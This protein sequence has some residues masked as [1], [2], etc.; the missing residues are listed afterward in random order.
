MSAARLRITEIFHS[1]QGEADTAGHLP[2]LSDTDLV[3][4]AAAA[5]HD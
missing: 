5:S 4:L 2:W 1:L 3:L